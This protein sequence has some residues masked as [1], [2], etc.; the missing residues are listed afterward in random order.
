MKLWKV[1][2]FFGDVVYDLRSRGL[3]PVVILLLIA[4]VAVPIV[5]SRGSSDTP[6]PSVQPTAGAANAAVET[7]S[8]VV[9]YT[10]GVR[11]YRKRLNDL[12]PENPFRQQF[13]KSA[14][15][16][17]QLNSTV[18]TA[19]ATS[20]GT[21][22]AA[23]T[24]GS[25]TVVSPGDTGSTGSTGGSKKKKKK[26]SSKQTYTYSV[27]VYAGEAGAALTPFTN[28]QPLTPLPNPTSPV[29]AFYGL[30]TDHQQALFLVSNKVDNVTGSGI[31]LP[32]PDDCALLALAGGQ[33]QDLHY[34]KDGK[35]YRVATVIKRVAK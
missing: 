22:D 28:V 1:Q 35:T 30:S 8:A 7:E 4:M 11:D 23:S 15:A 33:S 25:G 10:P 18:N 2:K 12:S 34:T 16:A 20:V 13:T 26:K 17:S 29:V 6:A 24:T 9:S 27:D 14:A 32:A 19:T 21:S 31:C 3:L 5:I